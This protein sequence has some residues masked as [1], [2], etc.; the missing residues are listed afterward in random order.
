MNTSC[1]NCGWECYTKFQ[2]PCKGCGQTLNPGWRP[3]LVNICDGCKYRVSKGCALYLHP[4]TVKKLWADQIDPPE[5]CPKR[6]LFL[7]D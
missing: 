4:C 3:P 5:K 7:T 2:V 6:E 1:P